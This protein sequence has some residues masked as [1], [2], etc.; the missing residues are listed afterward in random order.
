V[1]ARIRGRLIVVVP[2]LRSTPVIA[3]ALLACVLSP[4]SVAAQDPEPGFQIEGSSFMALIVQDLD[5][6]AGWY[7]EVLG[8][9]E[10]NRLAGAAGVAVRILRNEGL[11]VELIRLGETERPP[12]RHLGLFK[13]GFHVSDLDA[14]L[15]WL[16]AHDVET[17]GEIFTDDALEARSLVF[18]DPE[19]N[20]L[21]MFQALAAG[22]SR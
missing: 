17:V 5:V 13:T 11:V 16:Q 15:G 8:L 10:V 21:Q 18:R 12:D 22:R 2:R 14:A 3:A 7:E 19:G 1:H 4:R 20:R 6:M 9:R